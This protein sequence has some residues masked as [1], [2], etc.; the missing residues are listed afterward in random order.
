MEKYFRVE[1]DENIFLDAFFKKHHKEGNRFK[2]LFEVQNA[3]TR[4]LKNMLY[5]REAK[6]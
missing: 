2:Y 6:L 3:R 1:P 4:N 5:A